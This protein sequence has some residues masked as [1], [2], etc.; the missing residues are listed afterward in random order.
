MHLLKDTERSTVFATYDAKVRKTYRGFQADER[1]R[2]EI[3]VLQHLEQV[4]C[5]FV[6]RLVEVQADELTIVVTHCGSPVEHLS[7]ERQRSLFAELRLYGVQH[8]DENI[9]NVTYRSQD[10]RFCV[11]DFEFA[12]LLT[13]A[14]QS[15]EFIERQLAQKF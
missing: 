5:P 11:V 3:F 2:T 12:R 7:A 4:E 15:L 9:R 14:E 1:L 8:G 10:G 6:P 13:A